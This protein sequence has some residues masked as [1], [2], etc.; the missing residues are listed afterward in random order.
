MRVYM[1]AKELGLSSKELL[2]FFSASGVSAASHM[3]MLSNDDCALARKTFKDGKKID[4]GSK[5][6]KAKSKSSSE[7]KIFIENKETKPLTAKKEV[8]NLEKI[9]QA[10]HKEAPI[11]QSFGLKENLF[12]NDNKKKSPEPLRMATREE[13]EEIRG[14][15]EEAIPEGG[16][17]LGLKGEEKFARRFAT[18]K[19]KRSSRRKRGRRVQQEASASEKVEISEIVIDKGRPLFEVAAL[20][21]KPDSELI[22]LLLKKGRVCNKNQIL[23][24][25]VIKDVVQQLGLTFTMAVAPVSNQQAKKDLSALGKDVRPPVVVIMGHVDHGKTSLLDY[26]L[27]TNV[28]A[29]EKG[30]ITQHISVYQINSTHGKVVFLDTPGHEAFSYLRKRGARVTDIVVLVVAAD[31]GVMPQ[32]IEAIKHA[33]EAEVPIIVAINKMD[34]VNPVTGIET[35]KRQL[36]QHN[37]MA[38]DWGGD[39]I[40]VQVSAKTGQG[41]DDLLGMISLQAQMM[42]LKGNAET[43]GKAFIVESRLDKGHGPV[44]AA[45]CTEGTIKVGDYFVCG[46]NTGK[47]RLLID[48]LGNKL[49]SAGPSTPINIVGFNGNTPMGDWLSVVPVEVYLKA[50]AGKQDEK[51]GATGFMQQQ[52]PFAAV[53]NQITLILK[54]DTRGSL[55]ALLTSIEK[56]SKAKK[57]IGCSVVIASNGIGDITENDIDFASSIGA[58]ILGFNV[59]AEKN[60]VLIAKEKSVH[61]EVFHIIYQLIEHLEKA[62]EAR[63]VIKK[64]WKKTGEAVVRKV[65]DIKGIGIIA[66]CYLREGICSRTSKVVCMRGNKKIGEGKITSLQRDRKSVKEIHTGFEFGFSADVFHDWQE[67]DIVQCFTEVEVND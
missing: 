11:E 19:P 30:G 63:K 60:A 35:I 44:A 59:K 21:G 65:F 23:P 33:R 52:D 27:K 53:K 14:V 29:R 57:D 58:Q 16:K 41:V 4:S 10:P 20:M 62:L 50:R 51:S 39:T 22:S 34:K 48:P 5:E 8:D 47:I 9:Q 37:V 45:I 40:F 17:V 43:P 25:D 67:D 54:T 49:A 1:L 24:V 36:A 66:G 18:T 12:Y 56:L 6:G 55:E 38:E 46:E 64:T 32:T 7:E 42:E 61:V 3:S 15:I 31:D 2:A 26:I 13:E 28:T